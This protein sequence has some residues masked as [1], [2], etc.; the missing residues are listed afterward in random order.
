MSDKRND[1]KSE[2]YVQ[3]ISDVAQKYKDPEIITKGKEAGFVWFDPCKEINLW[4]YW[5]GWGYKDKTPDIDIMLVGQDWDNP[6]HEPSKEVTANIASMNAGKDIRYLD[7]IK[8][9]SA[10]DMN[11]ARLF[12]EL[13]S[14]DII[15][16]R[17]NNLFFTNFFLGY[18]TTEKKVNMSIMKEDAPEFKRLC[19]IIEPNVIICLGRLAYSAAVFSFTGKTPAFTS[20]NDFLDAGNNFLEI[21]LNSKTV[22]IYAVSHC[23]NLGVNN[24]NK[25]IDI[26]AEKMDRLQK[27]I[28]D[29]KRISDWL[30]K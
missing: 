11:L 7:N 3:L 4:T 12:K 27:Q 23:G 14:Y 22:R 16:K 10:T 29:W 26:K 21:K 18:K 15:N 8:V 9:T 13:G 30:N 20:F 5:Q 24:R 28:D 19:H 6:F 2:Q 25:G 1:Q 17:Y